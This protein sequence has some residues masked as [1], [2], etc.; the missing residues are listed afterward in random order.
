M[1][2]LHRPRSK[3]RIKYDPKIKG[4]RSGKTRFGFARVG[5]RLNLYMVG[6]KGKR[7]LYASAML[8]DAEKNIR[9]RPL[10]GDEKLKGRTV[11]I[12]DM[13]LVPE[14]RT[15]PD[16]MYTEPKSEYKGTGIYA[17]YLDYCRRRGVKKIKAYLREPK[18]V[19]HYSSLGLKLK[20]KEK[21]WH[22]MELDL[23]R[24]KK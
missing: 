7:Q 17:A 16:I 11:R 9:G 5:H 2:L 20:R 15:L 22:L 24:K 19:Q 8:V 12:A 18:L 13:S 1:A 21:G 6:E 4:Y 3:F 23:Q 14:F 10:F